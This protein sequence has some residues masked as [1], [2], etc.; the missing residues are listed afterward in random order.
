M[1]QDIYTSIANKLKNYKNK[2]IDI[3]KLLLLS[4]DTEKDINYIKAF[5]Y[6][7]FENAIEKL[8]TDGKLKPK[9]R[10]KKGDKIHSSFYVTANI[11]NNKNDNKTILEISKLNL[12]SLDYYLKNQEIYRRHRKYINKLN[13]Y[14]SSNP[15]PRL[16]SNELAFKLFNDEKF[17]ENPNTGVNLGL[18]ILQNLKMTYE[19]FNSYRTQE[20]FF[21]YIK[22]SFFEKSIRNILVI[23]NKDTFFTLIKKCYCD[24]FDMIIY[25]EGKKIISSFELAPEFNIKP[26]DTIRYFGDVDAEGFYIYK[27]FKEKFTQYNVG[28]Y[29]PIYETLLDQFGFEDLPKLKTFMKDDVFNGAVDIIKE[30]F[31]V[32]YSQK[33]CD[34]LANGRYLPQ[35]AAAFLSE[36][37]ELTDIE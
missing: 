33:I 24:V 1:I 11:K 8:C 32:A 17:F 31:D 9:G 19:D 27:L 6:I 34:I 7:E 5:Y 21:Y 30:E 13:E 35:E 14:Y 22:G 15:K 23:E 37:W 3:R 10:I 29:K 25:G 16:T 18:E 26:A 36:N 28:L 20:P 4:A 12:K 2:T